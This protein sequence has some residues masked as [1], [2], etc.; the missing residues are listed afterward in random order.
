[1]AYPNSGADGYARNL[2]E[3]IP[4]V[5][6]A[7]MPVAYKSQLQAGGISAAVQAFYDDPDVRSMWVPAGDYTWSQQVI[8]T[9]GLDKT[10]EFAPGCRLSRTGKF[11][12]IKIIAPFAWVAAI[13]AVNEVTADIGEAASGATTRHHQV[14]FDGPTRAITRGDR[15]KIVSD[16]ELLNAKAGSVA[17]K[18]RRGEH[19]S[20]AAPVGVAGTVGNTAILTGLLSETY[21]T[22]PRIAAMSRQKIIIR[23][24]EWRDAAG[25]TD[26]AEIGF[27]NLIGLVDPEVSDM[28][29]EDIYSTGVRLAGCWAA[30]VDNV[31]GR[32]GHNL[33][34]DGVYP[35]LI[36]D[37]GSTGTVITFPKGWGMRHVVTTNTDV[38]PV[39]ANEGADSVQLIHEHGRSRQ[40][41]CIGGYSY[42]ASNTGFDTHDETD[43]Y[44]FEGCVSV[45]GY[46]GPE[47]GGGGFSSRGRDVRFEGCEAYFCRNGFNIGTWGLTE[48]IRP[49][50]LGATLSAL[51]VGVSTTANVRSICR[52][53]GG[54]LQSVGNA[55]IVVAGEGNAGGK[56]P[57]DLDIEG[58]R[59][60]AAGT[61][62]RSKL[63][64]LNNARL[65]YRN[66][67]FDVSEY[68]PSAAANPATIELFT[69]DNDIEG[70]GFGW[71]MP[72][73]MPANFTALGSLFLVAGPNT[74]RVRM[75]GL[76][77]VGVP[78]ITSA[79]ISQ[80][81]IFGIPANMTGN[82]QVSGEKTVNGTR[83]VS[84]Y[85]AITAA[86]SGVINVSRVGD[87]SMI[88]RLSGTAGAV[89]MTN[90][91][92]TNRTNGDELLIAN[93]SNGAVTINSIAIAAGGQQ[94][95]A[96]INNVW[97]A[98]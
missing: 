57:V 89:S 39:A 52:V 59:L 1:M 24:G 70:D 95:F 60:A 87:R 21:P 91:A 55:S 12:P 83:S 84:S 19:A 38:T 41:R 81:N 31:I 96:V 26:T 74:S 11:N 56:S 35:Y 80:G 61:T 43:D 93:D 94:R 69:N 20:A 97:R 71:A 44:T 63:M 18:R 82:V 10:L 6:D 66:I 47:S 68:A 14:V 28:Q 86:A 58:T 77:Y 78:E 33:A 27:I 49:T 7:S 42:G 72:D 45:G 53:R 48:I 64:T 2:I 16:D 79:S 37:V 98:V 17:N 15:F 85:L 13:T 23:G 4:R 75:R 54:L 8:N 88:A 40:G 92:A 9:N 34:D 90:L 67:T 62:P 65:R 29:F 25:L 30:K 36:N 5:Y 46:A 50:V 76:N 73:V 32:N 22:T 51:E 3:R